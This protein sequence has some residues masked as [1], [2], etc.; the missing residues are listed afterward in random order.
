[1]PKKWERN[2]ENEDIMNRRL[3]ENR[4]MRQEVRECD[5]YLRVGGKKDNKGE[6]MTNQQMNGV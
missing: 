6:M 1:M 3:Q 2:E 4:N 5:I